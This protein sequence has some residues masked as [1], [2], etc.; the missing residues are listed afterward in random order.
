MT[1]KIN[2]IDD[3]NQIKADYDAEMSK[4]SHKILLCAGAGCV[5]C[6]CASVRDAI[7]AELN[8]LGL[9]DDVKMIETGC[10]GTCA[11]GPVMLILPERIFYTKLTPENVGDILRSQIIDG[12]IVEKQTFKD[13]ATGKFI[14]CIDDI[15]FFKEQIRIALR[16]CGNIEFSKIEAYI[17]NG[18]YQAAYKALTS[19]KPEDVI[20]EVLDSGLRGRGGA[21]FPTGKKWGFV[22]PGDQKYIVCNADEGD[23]GA[24][25]DR[26]IIE[27]D[28]H[29]LIEGMMLAG[30]AIGANQGYVYIR[31]EYPIAV[32][33]LGI[34]IEQARAAGLL[35]EHILGTDFNFDL[36]IRIGAGAFV[37]GEETA[38][39]ASIEGQR[40]E[41]RPK[42]PFPAVQGLYQ[43]PTIIN[44]V[45]TLANI[46]F[47][48][49]KG[50]S[51]YAKYGMEGATGTKVFALAGD[52]LNTGIIEVPIGTTLRKVI[53]DI[54]GGMQGG[55]KFKAAQVGGP[56]GGCV[57]EKNIDVALEYNALG[58][59]GAIM[60]SG[61]L[62]AMNEDT[63]MVDTARFFTDFTRDESCGKCT[64]CRIGMKR[65]LEILE[66]I[67]VGEGKPEDLDILQNLAAKVK[68]AALCGLG[69][70]A[71]NP[72]LSTIANFRDE[73]EAHIIDKR[74][75]AGICRKLTVFQI[76]ET[77]CV[78]CTL[79]ARNCPTGAITG[80]VKKPHKIDATVCIGCGVC[81]DNCRFSAI[82]PAKREN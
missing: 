56:S 78:G 16:N 29:N 52:I 64:A 71:P 31:A 46:A 1:T 61:G 39:L 34:A 27:G 43:K 54:G 8:N 41:P 45:E 68:A 19:M 32:D 5:S 6:D 12:E 73:Y 36:E 53:Y 81:R 40:G 76:D 17:A 49:D 23:P 20:Q 58:A 70:T 72:V 28:P 80:D 42:P 10:I 67:T 74:C 9:A 7:E 11:L 24:F 4:Y 14:P 26:S 47:I 59:I 18:G 62:I 13:N 21:G 33:R 69:Q 22:A 51:E 15:P 25:M 75:P 50:G 55:K 44:N 65:M 77:K 63:C 30:Y 66:R 60:G 38:L 57:T 82:S 79:C 48:V 35:G 3:L 37:C 2:S